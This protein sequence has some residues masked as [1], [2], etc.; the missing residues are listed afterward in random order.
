[1]SAQSP[2][3]Q[4][5]HLTTHAAERW[6]ERADPIPDYGDLEEQLWTAWVDA[7]P[8]SLPL[9]FAHGGDE[10][11]YHPDAKVV[12]C[13][14]ESELKTVFDVVGEDATLAVRRAVELQLDVQLETHDE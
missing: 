2:R 6:E 13:R 14:Q 3:P 10:A 8:I 7:I 9:P 4:P 5:P 11:R 1:M 12:L